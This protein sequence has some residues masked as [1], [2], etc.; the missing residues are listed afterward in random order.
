[1]KQ[2]QYRKISCMLAMNNLIMKF[3][4]SIYRV[5]KLIKYLRIN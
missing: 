1:M 2:G 5:S 4:N 3:K